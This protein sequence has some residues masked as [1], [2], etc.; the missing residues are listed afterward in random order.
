MTNIKTNDFVKMLKKNGYYSV[1]MNGSHEIFE[2]K[3]GDS[4][5][6]PTGKREMCGPMAKRLIKEHNLK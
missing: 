6:V 3:E 4:L 2:N 1:R 5:C